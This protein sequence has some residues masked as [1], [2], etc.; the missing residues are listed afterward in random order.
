MEQQTAEHILQRCRLL[1]HQ[2]KN[3]WPEEDGVMIHRCCSDD[4]VD[5]R[6]RKEEMLT[7]TNLI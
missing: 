3:G 7:F 6:D 1:E 4:S 2:R 5:R